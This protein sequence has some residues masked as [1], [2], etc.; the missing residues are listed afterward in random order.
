MAH[1]DRFCH[2][3][4]FFFSELPPRVEVVQR[5]AETMAGK[6]EEKYRERLHIRVDVTLLNHDAPILSTTCVPVALPFDCFT[7]DSSAPVQQWGRNK[8]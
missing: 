8:E 1:F 3:Q 7:F 5:E 2:L 6:C 4:I